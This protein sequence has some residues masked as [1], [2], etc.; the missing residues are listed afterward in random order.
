MGVRRQPHCDQPVTSRHESR[1]AP[2][3]EGIRRDEV[4]V[5]V[6]VIAS[7]SNRPVEGHVN[8]LKTLTRQMYGRAGFVLRK[9]RVVRVA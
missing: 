7:W 3:A 8:R 6:A 4:A 1:T 2:V 9:A 5:S